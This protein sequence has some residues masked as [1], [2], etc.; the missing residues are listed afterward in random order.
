MTPSEEF[1]NLI[2]NKDNAIL[3]NFIYSWG[4]TSNNPSVDL[5]YAKFFLQSPE[6]L[7]EK[8][9][10]NEDTWKEDI[11]YNIDWN[12]TSNAGIEP[13]ILTVFIISLFLSTLKDIIHDGLKKDYVVR[14]ENLKAKVK[15]RILHGYNIRKNIIPGRPDR[16]FCSFQEYT[17]DIPVN[18]LLKTALIISRDIIDSQEKSSA[19]FK[20]NEL[21]STVEQCL[22]NMQTVSREPYPS[23][24]VNKL[25]VPHGKL[26]RHYEKAVSLA[27]TIIKLEDAYFISERDDGKTMFPNFWIYLPT[28]FEH[29][30][31]GKMNTDSFETDEILIQQEGVFKQRA[32][33][34]FL[35]P[36]MVV[37]AKYKWWYKD[38]PK[39]RQGDFRNDFRELAGY[40]R[41]SKY[42]KEPAIAVQC[43]IV[44]PAFESAD[45]TNQISELPEKVIQCFPSNRFTPIKP[46]SE[47]NG[48]YK[49]GVYMPRKVK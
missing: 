15:G 37:D 40:A 28:V 19:I 41:D 4:G 27:K 10:D 25:V 24:A 11:Y 6:Y 32:D 23:F 48:F 29:Y 30:V 46:I 3:S 1:E 33:F 22:A 36:P 35:N 14:T 12:N 31:Y 49:V 38:I 34:I 42:F 16:F 17:D 5:D 47:L 45:N 13:S 44:Y 39:D 2:S 20:D 18:R 8:F 26:F 7:S 9:E 43:V 21:T